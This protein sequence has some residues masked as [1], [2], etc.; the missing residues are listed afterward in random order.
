MEF[1]CS[2]LRRHFAGKTVVASSNVGCFLRLVQLER[3]PSRSF[4]KRSIIR[5]AETV[6]LPSYYFQMNGSSDVADDSMQFSSQSKFNGENIY[7]QMI[8]IYT[9]SEIMFMF[10]DVDECYNSPCMN[11]ASSCTNTFGSYECNC[12][13]GFTGRHCQIGKLLPRWL[14]GGVNI[15]LLPT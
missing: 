1:F 4:L 15:D 10:S 5:R 8:L 9:Q 12:A 11:D 13:S 6:W 2:F 7:D 3:W 14:L